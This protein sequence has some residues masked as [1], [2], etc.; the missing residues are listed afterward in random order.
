MSVV[1]SLGYCLRVNIVQ[2]FGTYKQA[3]TKEFVKNQCEE[4]DNQ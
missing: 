2:E 4:K 1:R 3:S